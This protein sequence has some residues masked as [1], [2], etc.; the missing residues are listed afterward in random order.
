MLE[1]RKVAVEQI[2]Q[3]IPRDR[4]H[5]GSCAKPLAA[6]FDVSHA[7]RP[8]RERGPELPIRTCAA[9]GLDEPSSRIGVELVERTQRQAER[10]IARA[11]A[12]HPRQDGGKRRRGRFANRLIQRRE[13]ERLPQHLPQSRRLAVV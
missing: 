11:A 4:R 6:R 2:G 12:E 7:V 1:R 5:D 3:R 9:T 13:R 8:R 10:R